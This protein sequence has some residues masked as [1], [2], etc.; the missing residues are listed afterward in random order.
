MTHAHL[1]RTV[2]R[3]TG[4]SLATIRRMGFSIADPVEVD[5]DPEPIAAPRIIDWDAD[6]SFRATVFFNR[7][8]R[9]RAA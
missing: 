2:A 5:H 4:E 7:M 9:R 3:V 6:D 8:S 1:Q